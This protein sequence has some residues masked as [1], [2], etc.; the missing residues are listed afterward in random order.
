MVGNF[1][2]T[3]KVTQRCYNILA[4]GEFKRNKGKQDLSKGQKNGLNLGE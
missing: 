3:S 1:V 2:Q 4:Q